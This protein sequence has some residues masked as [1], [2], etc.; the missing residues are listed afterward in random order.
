MNIAF[1]I[2]LIANLLFGQV[3]VNLLHDAHDFHQPVTELQKE[4]HQQGKSTLQKHGEHCKIC[5]LD[6]LFNL[7][8]ASSQDIESFFATETV[9]YSHI[10]AEQANISFLH[11]RAPPITIF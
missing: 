1:P 5:S 3:I 7:L 11:G 4:L 10:A 6:I 8:P 2:I 9:I